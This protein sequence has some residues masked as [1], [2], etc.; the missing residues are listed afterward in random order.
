[1]LPYLT[2]AVV[3][4]HMSIFRSGLEFFTGHRA[5]IADMETYLG[6]NEGGAFVPLPMRQTW[7]C[8]TT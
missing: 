2:D 8:V 4:D 5:Y 3:A 7:A 6:A 1:M